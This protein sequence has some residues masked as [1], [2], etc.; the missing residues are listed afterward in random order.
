MCRDKAS[1]LAK[2]E[3]TIERYQRR[4]DDLSALKKQV[5][6]DSL[7]PTPLPLPATMLFTRLEPGAG[8]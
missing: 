7:S 6:S 2:A 4:I 8:E 5:L 1:R 3:D